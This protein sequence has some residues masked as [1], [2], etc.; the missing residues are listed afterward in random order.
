MRS[1]LDNGSLNSKKSFNM[2]MHVWLNWFCTRS[3]PVYATYHINGNEPKL[4]LGRLC[5]TWPGADCGQPHGLSYMKHKS[6]IR[7]QTDRAQFFLRPIANYRSQKVENG[8][9]ETYIIHLNLQPSV[10]LSWF[11]TC[12]LIYGTFPVF[13][14]NKQ[15][16]AFW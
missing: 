1:L 11:T 6:R 14:E 4:D 2:Q 3:F 9:F 8:S 7:H 16:C 12:I 5:C 15:Q 10:Q 13:L